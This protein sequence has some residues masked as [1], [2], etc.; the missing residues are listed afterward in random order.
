MVCLV[1]WRY[2]VFRLSESLCLNKAYYLK[3]AL[4]LFNLKGIF[5]MLK[6]YFLMLSLFALLLLSACSK[7]P[8]ENF[9]GLWEQQVGQRVEVI[10]ITQQG[11][12]F[13]LNDGVLNADDQSNSNSK[14]TVLTKAEGQLTVSTG[15][16]SITFAL[17]D[18]DTLIIADQRFKRITP[19]RVAEIKA[20]LAQQALERQ[21]ARQQALD[22]QEQ[23]RLAREAERQAREQEQAKCQTLVDEINDEIAAIKKYSTNNAKW[24]AEYEKIKRTYT[25]IAKQY[26]NC[27]P[28]FF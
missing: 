17:I 6:P 16:G 15:F 9:P 21:R 12:T 18:A 7:N 19:D 27:K 22:L 20:E 4:M 11:D 8:Y 10:E 13:L 25:E 5:S 14:V 26:S 23:E 3:L 1:W 2:Y 28:D 24:T